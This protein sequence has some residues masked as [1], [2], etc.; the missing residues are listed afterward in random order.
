MEKMEVTD[1]RPILLRP[2]EAARLLGVSRSKLYG[3]LARGEVPGIVKIGASTRISRV[4]M[5]RWIA[6]QVA[7]DKA[8]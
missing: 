3:L 5:E 7:S 2:A 1:E 4:V 6:D 8:A